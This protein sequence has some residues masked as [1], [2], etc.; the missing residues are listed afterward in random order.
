MLWISSVV[1]AEKQN[2]TEK[3]VKIDVALSLLI[4]RINRYFLCFIEFNVTME[5]NSLKF[6][7]ALHILIIKSMYPMLYCS[8][9][10]TNKCNAE[11]FN[12]L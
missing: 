7:F 6:S 8:T 11:Q 12:E 9:I 10:Y 1:Y 5:G 2:E 4:D 3:L